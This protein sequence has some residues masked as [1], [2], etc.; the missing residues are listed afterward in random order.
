MQKYLKTVQNCFFSRFER[1]LMNQSKY[2]VIEATPG[3][4][5]KKAPIQTKEM[6][7]KLLDLGKQTNW[8]Y[9]HT[10]YGKNLKLLLSCTARNVPDKPR[11]NDSDVEM[12]NR[13]KDAYQSRTVNNS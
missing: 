1:M 2:F 3:N 10:E 11:D 8:K 6:L 5:Q 13:I 7:T 12:N 9:K 4:K